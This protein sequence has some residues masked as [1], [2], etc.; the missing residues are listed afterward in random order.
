MPQNIFQIKNSNIIESHNNINENSLQQN[1]VFKSNDANQN[2]NN[3]IIENNNQNFYPLKENYG[4]I[5]SNCV[6]CNKHVIGYKNGV[7]VVLSMFIGESALIA[8]WIVFNN[9]IFPFYL[10]IIGGFFYLLTVIF[11]L[12]SFLTEPGIIPRNHPDYAI[13]KN[14]DIKKNNNNNND[15]DNFTKNKNLNGNLV[16]T[17][18]ESTNK[19]NNNIQNNAN[20]II[21]NNDINNNKEQNPR[22]FTIRNC[23]TCK[24]IRPPGA[25][26]CST[27]D[28]CV[29]NFDHHCDFISNCVG[30]RNHKYFYL[31][32]F[33]GVLTSIYC[34]VTQIITIIKV[35]I[36]SPKGFYR[37]LWHDN[38][39]LFLLSLIIMFLCLIL[40]PCLRAKEV[41]LCALAGG[42]ILFVVVFYVY[43]SRKGKPKY[44]NPFILLVLAFTIIFLLSVGGAFINQTHNIANGFTV[45]QLHSIQEAINNDKQINKEYLRE[46][47][48]GE[49][50]KNLWE[51]LKDEKG[52]SLIIPERDLFINESK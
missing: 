37:E 21:I 38:K 4:N 11:N 51:F 40:L 32:L 34:F 5:G 47:S 31:F 50:I 14:D 13:I 6:L 49:K 39:W 41:L 26:H 23:S 15:N 18:I 17:N 43:Y 12:L 19:S 1:P 3:N 30:K 20:N 44:Y 10:Y 7:F 42:Y 29:L 2:I 27:C 25:S 36:I 28:N 52:Q 22:I 8:A 24:I 46:K 35:F 9:T 45:K 33:F 16:K 48:L